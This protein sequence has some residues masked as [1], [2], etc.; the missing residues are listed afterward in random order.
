MASLEDR[1]WP[2]V[3]PEPNSGCWLWEGAVHTN[4]YGNFYVDG[5]YRRAHRVSYEMH[6]GQIP[7]GLVIDHLCRNTFCVNPDHLEPVTHGENVRRGE[8]R[9]RDKTHCKWGHEFTPDNTLMRKGGRACRKCAK[10]RM[11]KWKNAKTT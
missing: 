2:K 5:K 6:K 8:N 11:E 7:D 1:F 9:N 4:G 3:S 10:I